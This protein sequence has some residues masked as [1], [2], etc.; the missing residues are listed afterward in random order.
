MH[1][2]YLDLIEKLFSIVIKYV[3]VS[4][5]GVDNARIMIHLGISK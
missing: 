3:E 4:N 2:I 5:V 1:S